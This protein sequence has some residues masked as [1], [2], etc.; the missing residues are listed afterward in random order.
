MHR[1]GRLLTR[2]PHFRDRSIASHPWHDLE[3]GPNA[4]D[5]IHAVI[6]IPSAGPRSSTSS[7]R[8]RYVLIVNDAASPRAHAHAD[9][10]AHSR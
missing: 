2:A 3:I 5:V 10:H 1:S 9:A 7:T 4:P 8:R 6:E